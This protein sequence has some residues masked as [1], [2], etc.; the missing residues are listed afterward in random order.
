M[1]TRVAVL[2]S[3]ASR[4]PF[5]RKFVPDYKDHFE[6][7]S[8]VD[9]VSLVSMAS[10]QISFP[11]EDLSVLDARN[12]LILA[13]ELR[14]EGFKDIRDS[15]PEV[16]VVDLWA[17]AVMGF[18]R[19]TD[20]GIVTRNFWTVEKTDF[21]KERLEKKTTLTWA[22][23]E[24]WPMFTAAADAVI[25]RIR[26]EN[27]GLSIVLHKPRNVGKWTD[28]DGEIHAF[29][30]YHLTQNKAWVKADAWF[31]E[32][33]ADMVIDLMEPGQ[34]SY[35]EHPWGAFPVHYHSD[36]HQRFIRALGAVTGA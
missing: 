4:D 13:K 33:H 31:A 35:A 12:Q 17:D 8:L 18:A 7:V 28:K 5:N 27:P 29:D 30:G 1:V 3:C 34:M 23:D 11:A 9:K 15:R 10:P 26:L 16:L 6:C 2:G 14:R 24:Y 25:G 32:R 22:H 19:L 36:Y 20:G 21:Y